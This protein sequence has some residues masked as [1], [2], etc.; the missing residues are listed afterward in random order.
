MSLNTLSVEPDDR[1]T[2]VSLLD[3]ILLTDEVISTGL[4]VTSS[5]SL[6]DTFLAVEWLALLTEEPTARGD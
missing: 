6:V 3:C 2:D 5:T 4:G 1:W